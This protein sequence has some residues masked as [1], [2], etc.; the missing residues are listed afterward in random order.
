MSGIVRVL[1]EQD[2]W[3][4]EFCAFAEAWA[5]ATGDYR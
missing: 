3:A 5:E 2:E 1:W 4:D